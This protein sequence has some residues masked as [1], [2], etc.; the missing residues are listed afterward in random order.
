M[1][2]SASSGVGTD[3]RQRRQRLETKLAHKTRILVAVGRERLA[4]VPDVP[5][6]SIALLLAVRVFKGGI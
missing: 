6:M 1:F 4:P 5:I 3:G 2:Q